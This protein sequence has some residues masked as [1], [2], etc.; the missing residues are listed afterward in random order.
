MAI[1]TRGIK[2]SEFASMS[3]S[4]T[5]RRVGELFQSAVNPTE[6]Q[7]QEQKRDI[8]EQI[9]TFENRYKMS[10][11]E[12]KQ[13]LANGGLTENADVCNWLM[14]L[15]IRGRFESKARSPRT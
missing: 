12:M 2:L 10:S 1:L 5:K 6:K 8:D 7:F 15:K 13:L 11:C 3:E 4:E 9:R 14:L